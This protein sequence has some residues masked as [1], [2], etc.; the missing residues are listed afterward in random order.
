MKSQK[1]IIGIGTFYMGDDEVRSA[2]WAPGTYRSQWC[3]RPN[4]SFI[5]GGF[6]DLKQDGGQ[7]IETCR[8]G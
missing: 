2:T 7:S 8:G 1:V 3:N 6:F 5:R 4:P